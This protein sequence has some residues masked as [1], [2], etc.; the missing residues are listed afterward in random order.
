MLQHIIN[1]GKSRFGE[2]DA[3]SAPA[4]TRDSRSLDKSGTQDYFFA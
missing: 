2:A 3:S 1:T 4:L